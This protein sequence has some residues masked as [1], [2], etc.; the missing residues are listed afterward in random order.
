M[1]KEATKTATE[2]QKEVKKIE[3][4]SDLKT[5]K[6]SGEQI[7]THPNLQFVDE[8]KKEFGDTIGLKVYFDEHGAFAEDRLF[9]CKNDLEDYPEKSILEFINKNP[10]LYYEEISNNDIKKE[11]A[12]SIDV[13]L[14]E[15]GGDTAGV[16]LISKLKINSLEEVQKIIMVSPDE[17]GMPFMFIISGKE[18]KR[19]ILVGV[20]FKWGEQDD[21]DDLYHYDKDIFEHDVIN[22]KKT[23]SEE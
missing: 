1:S 20:N 21:L 4:L 9:A 16:D 15:H 10:N 8:L 17:D 5:A 12:A 14:K 23:D 18:Y 7:W 22:R 19:N 11:I 6:V 2:E 13:M 3:K